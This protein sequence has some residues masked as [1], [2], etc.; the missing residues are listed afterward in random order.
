LDGCSDAVLEME[1]G[2]DAGDVVGDGVGG[3][4]SGLA[5][6]AKAAPG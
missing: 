2:E 5:D 1:F 6:E 3:A 4:F